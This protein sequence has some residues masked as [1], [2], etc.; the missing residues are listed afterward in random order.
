MVAAP[1]TKAR[2]RLSVVTQAFCT[3]RHALQLPGSAFV[4]PPK[5]DASV[6]VL[7]PRTQQQQSNDDTVSFTL[8]E[9]AMRGLFA[10][11]RKTALNNARALLGGDVGRAGD[12]LAAT[13]TPHA[14]RPQDLTQ[15]QC[16]ALARA[17]PAFDPHWHAAALAARR[18]DKT[19]DDGGGGDGEL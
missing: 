15:A 16:M 17:L 8:L 2:T 5:V 4:P 9:H 6:V 7:T 13:H 11:R 14:T 1:S 19:P 10:M 3:A 12:W 18:L